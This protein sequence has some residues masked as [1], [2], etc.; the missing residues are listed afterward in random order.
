ME[1]RCVANWDYHPE[2]RRIIDPNKAS[3][4]R[5]GLSIIEQNSISKLEVDICADTSA[6]A[7]KLA[8]EKKCMLLSYGMSCF[9]Q[10]LDEEPAPFESRQEELRKER[11]TWAQE[12]QQLFLQQ[13]AFKQSCLKHDHSYS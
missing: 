12:K 8:Y 4:L 9:L 10:I 6:K 7:R 5:K 2:T 1:R 11:I 3:K 13:F